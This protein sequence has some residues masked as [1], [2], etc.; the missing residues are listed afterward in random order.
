[1]PGQPLDLEHEGTLLRLGFFQL[2]D[3]TE[4]RRAH[5]HPE[6]EGPIGG[7]VLRKENRGQEGHAQQRQR[8]RANRLTTHE[9]ELRGRGGRRPSSPSGYQVACPPPNSLLFDV[10]H[11]SPISPAAAWCRTTQSC[12]STIS[13]VAS[14][15]LYPCWHADSSHFRSA[16]EPGNGIRR[17]PSGGPA[18]L[19]GRRDRVATGSWRRCGR[20][21][22]PAPR[23]D[24]FDR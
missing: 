7:I 17:F 3:L 22:P 10:L 6:A 12:A 9:N 1:M 4:F 11:G 19:S 13:R 2:H 23:V 21:S 18:S 5:S 14:A 24:R 8:Q 16:P 15:N 20:W